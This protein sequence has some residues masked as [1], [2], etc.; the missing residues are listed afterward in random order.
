MSNEVSSAKSGQ[1]L[2]VLIV[3]DSITFSGILKRSILAKLDVEIELCCDYASTV[4]CLKERRDEFFVALL[5]IVLPDAPDGEVVDLVVSHNIPSIVFTGEISDELRASMWSKRIVDYVQKVNFDDIEH[6]VGLVDRLRKNLF[7]KVL[8]ADS[9]KSTRTLFRELLNVF[10]FQVVEVEDGKAALEQIETQDIHLLISGYDLPDMEGAALV[11]EIRKSYS[12]AKLPII[13]FSRVAQATTTSEVLK[14]GAN[15][16]IN[17]PFVP[18]EFYCRVANTVDTAEYIK[19]IKTIS[20]NDSLTN[21]FTR[22][23]LFKYGKKLFGQQKRSG[24]TLV[25]VMLDIDNISAYN[26]TYG[27]IVGDALIRE[28][29]TVLANRFRKGDVVSRYGGDTFCV[30][31]AD[32]KLQYVESVFKELTAK[33]AK[34]AIEIGEYQLNVTVCAGINTLVGDN[35]EDMVVGAEKL[36]REAKKKG[37]GKVECGAV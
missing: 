34:D 16:F 25:A 32:M 3:E 29:A 28:V 31:C 19:T 11:K 8:V 30:L 12:K 13:G 27:Q 2:K 35:L 17:S 10:N 22:R 9:S 21:L 37:P 6:V 26:E 24:A 4:E 1:Q 33:I 18:E 15:D 14:S 7:Q 20:D 5:D 23:S 36:L